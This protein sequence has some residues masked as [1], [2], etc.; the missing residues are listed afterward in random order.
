MR[1]DSLQDFYAKALALL[2]L[3]VLAGAGALVDYWPTS[4]SLPAVARVLDL[5]R[6]PRVVLAPPLSRPLTVAHMI[7]INI[8]AASVPSPRRARSQRPVQTHAAVV[9]EVSHVDP[10]AAGAVTPSSAESSV[11]V[12]AAE[13]MRVVVASAF[14]PTG[15]PARP[16]QAEATTVST[17]AEPPRA[18]HDTYG[19]PDVETAFVRPSS[20]AT[21]VASASPL[22]SGTGS[23]DRDSTDEGGFIS[24][25]V[26]KTGASILKGGT[27]TGTSI[28]GAIRALGGA[29]RRAFP[30]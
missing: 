19:S 3:G 23:G 10:A 5:P 13:Q 27:K 25:A 15:E 21:N 24:G 14:A 29:M 4:H 28:V 6:A 20:V 26:R 1:G 22:A 12:S 30:G 2:G 11:V 18:T 17:L 7:N 9:A 8:D 16:T